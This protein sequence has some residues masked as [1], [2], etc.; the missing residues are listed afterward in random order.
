MDHRGVRFAVE[1]GRERIRNPVTDPARPRHV[2]HDQPGELAQ[3]DLP[4]KFGT[5][6]RGPAR[7]Q[8]TVGD[9]D[10]DRVQCLGLLDHQPQPV[11]HGN[12]PPQRQFERVLD[13][14]VI[15]QLAIASLAQNR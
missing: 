12:G 9:V 5:E 2:D 1:G 11:R 3:A 7:G 14:E 10:V 15:E 13:A 6:R 8:G 4:G